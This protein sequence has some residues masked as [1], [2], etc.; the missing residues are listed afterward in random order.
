MSGF[1]RSWPR[2]VR[3]L[4]AALLCLAALPPASAL[5]VLYSSSLNGNMDG[6]ACRTNPRAGLATRAAWLRNDARRAGALLVDAGDLLDAVPDPE[7]AR[8]L[9]EAYV[10]LGYDAV[11]V[12]DQE[13]SCGLQ[14]LASWRGRFPLKAH[15]LTLCLQDRCILFD[16]EPLVLS[17]G[18]ETVGLIAL[19]DPQVFE[20]RPEELR[21]NLKLQAPVAAAA[22]LVSEL[23]TRPVDWVVVL[24]HG[25]L[26]QAERLAEQV[27]G[28]DLIVVGHE[29]RLVPP[30]LV[31]FTL[32]ASPGEEG[33][34]IGLLTL[35][36]DS[37]RRTRSSHEF[38]L[39]RYDADPRDPGILERL[40]RYRRRLVDSLKPSSP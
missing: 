18:G 24:Y 23:R 37:R 25:P 2:V 31:N 11:A 8:E 15:N 14:E 26:E 7:L 9:L 30:R 39:F 36:K 6:C 34:R 17:K 38:R 27:R 22:P 12:G 16:T 35:R 32:L 19:L 20:R 29:Q 21:R 5:T 28:I 33:N 1:E 3:R 13:T 40:Q 10:E 4:G